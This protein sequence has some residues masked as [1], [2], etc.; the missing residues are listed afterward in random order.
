M[1]GS[2]KNKNYKI[3][4]SSKFVYAVGLLT[5]DGNLSNDGRHINFTS[6]D[7][8]LARTFKKCVD[9]IDVKIGMKTSGFSKKKYTS[10]QFSNV[11]LYNHLLKI[12]LTPNKSKT[13]GEVKIPDKYFFD[14]TR[15]HFD[16][17]GSCYSYWDKRWPNS[18][19]FY[20][21]FI[22]S[23]IAH[24]NWLR[25][26]IQEF[27]GIKGSIDVSRN[28]WQLQYAKRESII[29]WEKMYYKKNLPCLLRKYDKIKEIL[30]VQARV[31]QL[32]RRT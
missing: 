5:T 16:G 4:W 12:G 18:F 27:T 24:I 15:G 14:F 8:Q 11:K 19:M 1:R 20:T 2:Q 26:K 29:L 25:S 31:A 28:A 6:K 30:K 21:Y 23:S 9:L 32:V 7:I 3:R 22:S 10:I 13:L 17:D